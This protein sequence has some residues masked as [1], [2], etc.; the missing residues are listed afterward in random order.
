EIPPPVFVNAQLGIKV[1]FLVLRDVILNAGTASRRHVT[2]GMNNRFPRRGISAGVAII[3][4]CGNE[5]DPAPAHRERQTVAREASNFHQ[6]IARSGRWP[7]L[8]SNLVV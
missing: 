6:D 4:V 7:K 1:F 5:K 2:F 3:A 8:K